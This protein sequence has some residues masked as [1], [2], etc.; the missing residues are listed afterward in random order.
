MDEIILN[1]GKGVNQPSL[2]ELE[3]KI[4][5]ILKYQKRASRYAI[6]RGIISFIFFLVFIVLPII[7]GFYIAE[8]IKH[9]VDLDKIS[10]QYKE[11]TETIGTL[12]QAKDQIDKAKNILNPVNGS[13]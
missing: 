12:N 6:F 3:V 10:A 4:D 5:K 8:Y 13:N 9:R 2:A 11:L 7:G 1:T